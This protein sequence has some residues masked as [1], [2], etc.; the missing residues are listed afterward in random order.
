MSW[1]FKKIIK[2]CMFRTIIVL[3]FYCLLTSCNPNTGSDTD[4]KGKF[5]NFI[6]SLNQGNLPL[7]IRACS[8]DASHLPKPVNDSLFL[9]EN[10][11]PYCTFKIGNDHTAVISLVFCD[12]SIP[13][14]TTFDENGNKI[15]EKL[16]GDTNC[17]GIGPG[18]HCKEYM[19]IEKDF[20]IYA[21][22]TIVR[23]EVDSL[24]E[25]IKETVV[26][27]VLYQKGK[28]LNTG[29]IELSD[30]LRQVLKN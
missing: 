24:Q 21:A 10:F 2:K 4:R 22:D 30:T 16:L 26:K 17:G 27:Y 29:K 25:D 28:V 1:Q 18:F 19:S 8:V 20:S 12:C 5:T 7:V 6:G 3:T 9:A 14:L 11:V 15:D 13:Y 23:A